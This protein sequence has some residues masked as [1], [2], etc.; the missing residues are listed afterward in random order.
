MNAMLNPPP[1][2]AVTSAL[3]NITP[4]PTKESQA[5]LTEF[6][7]T[8]QGEV[9]RQ[10]RSALIEDLAEDSHLIAS[11]KQPLATLLGHQ[12]LSA[13]LVPADEIASAQIIAREAGVCCGTPWV[14]ATLRQF[15]PTITYH[16]SIV[17]G[18][19]ITP[20]YKLLT[21]EGS[22][23]S[24]LTVERTLLNFMQLL[25][26]V[27]TRCRQYAD[28]V[29]HTSV[30]V[31]DTRKTLPG[32]RLAQKWAVA[33]GGCFNHRLGLYDAFL[34]KENHIAAAGGIAQTI[35]RA[36]ALAPNKSIEIEVE[37]LAEYQQAL[38]TDVD[39]IMLD[40][41]SIAEIRQAVA[42]KTPTI[43]LEV[44]GNVE[45]YD[46]SGA[47]QNTHLTA[48]AETGIDYIS[49]GALTKN[50]KALD[51]SMQLSRL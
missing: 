3:H 19:K 13:Q 21:L 50:V 24:L 39:V 8:W 30:K 25:S 17:E 5:L 45:L 31:L 44:S 37:T 23:R 36:R 35:A 28:A 49:V 33:K 32:L 7:K 41:F 1:K 10:V 51:L 40:N 22:A 43:K 20:E 6:P 48:L 46:C 16:W 27:A 26:G 9:E 12:D 29:S 4:Q 2:S 11:D 34:I 38:A 15:D 42:D 47:S 18:Q 14:E